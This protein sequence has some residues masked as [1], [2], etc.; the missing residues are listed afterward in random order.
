MLFRSISASGT[1]AGKEAMSFGG[2]PNTV[3]RSATESRSIGLM[4]G[5]SGPNGTVPCAKIAVLTR[6]MGSRGVRRQVSSMTPLYTARVRSTAGSCY[7]KEM[8]ESLA[9]KLTESL[10]RTVVNQLQTARSRLDLGHVA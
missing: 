1:L 5:G 8:A 7:D 6:K 10:M 4:T 3:A 2:V 9:R